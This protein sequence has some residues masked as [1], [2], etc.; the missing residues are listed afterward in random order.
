[1]IRISF[2]TLSVGLAVLA[3]LLAV[4]ALAAQITID[5]VTVGNPGNANDTGGTNNGAVN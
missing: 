4:P 5:M 1:M 2:N 3:C